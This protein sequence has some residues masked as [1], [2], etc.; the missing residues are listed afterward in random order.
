MTIRGSVYQV[1]FFN[2]QNNYTVVDMDCSG[3][4]I[5]AVGIFPAI[6][7][8][9]LLE[10]EGE[11]TN[12]PRFGEQ[13]KVGE[14]KFIEPT[15]NE[16][17]VAYLSSGLIKGLGKNKAK[18]IVDMFGEDT[19]E[20]I[21]VNPLALRK[22][23]GIGKIT[24]IKIGESYMENKSMKDA[25][26]YLQK[27]NITTNLA[28]KIFKA[29][30]GKTE[31]VISENPYKL[32]DDI[33]GVGFVTADRMAESMGI[34]K[35]SL[36]RIRAGIVY[37]MSYECT[38]A[39]NTCL[40]EED[41]INSTMA[42]LK[43]ED[44]DKV[45]E[46]LE[47]MKITGEMQETE[48]DGVVLIAKPLFYF[49]EKGIAHSLKRLY[50]SNSNLDVDLS[51][52]IKEFEYINNI[53]LHETQKQAIT[54]AVNRGVEIITG[55]PGTGKTTIIKAILSILKQKGRKVCLAAPT[56]RASKRLQDATGSKAQTIHRLLMVNHDGSGNSFRYNEYNKLP[57]DAIIVD[58][59]SMVDVV[60]FHSLLKALDDGTRLV[61]V[62]DKDQLPSVSPGNVLKDI[63]DSEVFSVDYLTH[64]YRQDEDSLIITN[65]HKINNGEMPTLSSK[66]KDFFFEEHLS[67][68]DNLN[69]VL[70]LCNRRLPKFLGVDSKEIQVLAPIKKTIDGVN[71][72]NVELQKLIN[73][74]NLNKQELNFGATIFREGDKVMH[75]VNN[76][77]LEWI[78]D[79]EEGSGVFNGDMG[80]IVK[81]D[82]KARLI[83]VLFE[84]GR[85]AV[86][87]EGEFDELT[88]SYAIS[89]HKSQ[90]SEFDAIVIC[91]SNGSHIMQ[92]R[93]LLYTAVTRAKK[94]V[95]IIGNRKNLYY[96]VKNDKISE[97][98]SLLK[99]FLQNEQDYEL[100]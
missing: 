17:I 49:S 99:Y 85:T 83:T 73:P 71:N 77:D 32:I 82:K 59:I 38:R 12:N 4:L 18:A 67:S 100:R 3:E 81:V 80:E 52:E 92:N 43:I 44:R 39:G 41:L 66:A 1:I 51:R 79:N 54:N 8:G 84:D 31:A 91:I 74:A 24:A 76:Y 46:V 15:N 70:D 7:E 68:V 36:L 93:N 42:I 62:G 75:T 19:L 60:L 22:V 11:M 23:K 47:K 14:V 28:I 34:K 26:I 20:I 65:A 87:T 69:T 35:D 56:G 9:E 64:I 6:S 33:N 50:N 40:V 78:S 72:L 96:M 45:V 63:I 30:K 86:Y 53:T 55:G 48:V 29:Y 10:L 27:F 88:L 97:R 94:L 21:E 58:E 89:I 57:Y 61:I 95:V 13:F 90:G 37:T 5:T 25:I 98:Y 16:E 2:E